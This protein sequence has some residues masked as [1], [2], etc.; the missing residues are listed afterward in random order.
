[1]RDLVDIAL[2]LYI[3]LESITIIIMSSLLIHKYIL[4]FI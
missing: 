4:P 1:M 2:N 3:N